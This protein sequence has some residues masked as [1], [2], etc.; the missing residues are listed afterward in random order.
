MEVAQTDVG[1]AKQLLWSQLDPIPQSTATVRE[2]Q[3][4]RQHLCLRNGECDHPA[5]QLCVARGAMILLAN[6]RPPTAT[7]ALS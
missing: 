7:I 5:R 6:D 1:Q 4:Y 3:E 2:P